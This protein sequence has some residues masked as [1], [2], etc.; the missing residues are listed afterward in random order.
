MS[1]FNPKEILEGECYPSKTGLL[2]SHLRQH[3]DG[4]RRL[5]KRVREII[6]NPFLIE[7]NLQCLESDLDANSYLDDYLDTDK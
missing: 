4:S 1:D 3:R 2:Q 6:D 7:V 5:I